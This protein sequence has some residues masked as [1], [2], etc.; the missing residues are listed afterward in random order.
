MSGGAGGKQLYLVVPEADLE[1]QE[2]SNGYLEL[3]EASRCCW[4][5]LGVWRFR[6]YAVCIWWYLRRIWSCRR[7]AVHI[8]RCLSLVV[9]IWRCRRR[10]VCIWRYTRKIWRYRWV[11]GGE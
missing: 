4:E 5:A 11:S 7:Q 10:A 9:S 6:M 1:V 3:Q 2:A 8:Q